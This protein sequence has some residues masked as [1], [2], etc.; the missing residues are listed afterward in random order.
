M[1]TAMRKL[2]DHS[3]DEYEWK[4]LADDPAYAAEIEELRRH[5]PEKNVAM[6]RRK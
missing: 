6:K 1:R 2:Y 5:L 3:Q 4:N